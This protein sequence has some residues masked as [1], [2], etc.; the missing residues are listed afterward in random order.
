MLSLLGACDSKSPD[1]VKSPAASRANAVTGAVV[2]AAFS[3]SLAPGWAL[4][5][6]GGGA[7]ATQHAPHAA[8]SLGKGQSLSPM[9][10]AAGQ[11]ATYTCTLNVVEAGEHRFVVEAQGGA[12]SISVLAKGVEAPVALIAMNADGV[13]R[14]AWVPLSAGAFTVTVKYARSGDGPARLRTMWERKRSGETPQFLLEPIPVESA[15]VPK[16]AFEA[17]AKAEDVARGRVLLGELNC[18]ACHAAPAEAAGLIPSR[19][20]PLLDEIGRRASPAWLKK[21]ITDPQSVKPGAGMPTLH[22][23][24]HGADA[25]GHAID[26]DAIT[27]FLVAPYYTASDETQP[28]ANE[29]P[30]LASGKRIYHQV[31]C[32]ACHGPLTPPSDALENP[33]ESNTIPKAVVSAPFG[34]MIGKWRPVALS[35]FLRDPLKAHP[36]GDRKSVV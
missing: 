13:G 17:V 4:V 22:V 10:S 2:P 11:T 9:V 19:Q 18:V 27:Q 15:S 16:F 29:R 6:R 23:A 3:G 25:A 12:A 1:A 30:V 14:S 28:V 35:A 20:A 31:G 32:V 21:W 34:D 26:A 5:V 7:E 36:S 33:S 24:G 8:F